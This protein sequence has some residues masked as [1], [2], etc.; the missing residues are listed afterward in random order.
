MHGNFYVPKAS[1]WWLHYIFNCSH[2]FPLLKCILFCY[3]LRPFYFCSILQLGHYVDLIICVGRLHYLW[4]SF[5][6]CKVNISKY[7]LK[8][9]EMESNTQE[10]ILQNLVHNVKSW[11]HMGL[12]MSPDEFIWSLTGERKSVGLPLQPSVFGILKH[13]KSAHR[14]HRWCAHPQSLSQQ[15][16]LQPAE[17]PVSFLSTDRTMLKKLRLFTLLSLLS[18]WGLFGY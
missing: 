9:G 13:S 4:M 3:K 1:I 10:N 11:H 12:F 14:A 2:T 7:L 18:L 17:K 6:Y 16:S 15:T 5:Q 8:R